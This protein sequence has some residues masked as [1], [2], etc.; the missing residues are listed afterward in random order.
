MASMVYKTERRVN[1]E[2]ALNDISEESYGKI[3]EFIGRVI[4]DENKAIPVLEEIKAENTRET[5]K[6]L[7]RPLLYHLEKVESGSKTNRKKKDERVEE[8]LDLYMDYMAQPKNYDLLGMTT[9]EF[10][11]SNPVY[12]GCSHIAVGKKL[13]K[14]AHDYPDS[15]PEPTKK[16]EK[17]KSGSP[18]MVKVFY[19]PVRKVTFGSLIKK[20]REQNGLSV[21]DFSELTGYDIGLIKSWEDD[22]NTPSHEAISNIEYVCGEHVFD[23]LRAQ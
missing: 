3:V 17:T 1:V 4:D 16:Y 18:N 7:S 22:M 20:C 5:S 11:E 8:I 9:H 6:L 19:V 10:I 12:L 21:R 15:I 14:I 13:A 23:A 2:F